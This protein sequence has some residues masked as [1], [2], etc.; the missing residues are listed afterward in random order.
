MLHSVAPLRPVQ[1]Y[2]HSATPFRNATCAPTS[3]SSCEALRPRAPVSRLQLLR[4]ATRS[5]C[6]LRGCALRLVWRCCAHSN[7]NSNSNSS[8]VYSCR[9][10]TCTCYQRRMLGGRG[11]F[12]PPMV[13]IFYLRSQKFLKFPAQRSNCA[14]TRPHAARNAQGRTMQKKIQAHAQLRGQPHRGIRHVRQ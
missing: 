7:S 6:V 3:L 2:L 11:L 5:T 9:A 1:L 12:L 13:F 8:C 10:H 4:S 14:C